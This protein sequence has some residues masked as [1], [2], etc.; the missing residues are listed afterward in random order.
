MTNIRF[1]QALQLNKALYDLKQAG[2]RW[3]KK[4]YDILTKIGLQRA[5]YDHAIFYRKENN[6]SILITFMHVDDIT[7][8]DKNIEVINQF[9]QELK[10]YVTYTN[11]NKLHWLLGIEITWS[12]TNKTISLHQKNYIDN[13]IRCFTFENE[14]VL[15]TLMQSNMY[16]KSTKHLLANDEKF[17]K[18]ILYMNMIDSL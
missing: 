9:K 10:K 14:L 4:I 18:D 12:R 17:I 11:D 15:K 2:R 7:I 16:L 3:Y 1:D 13:I 8:I 6:K 5:N